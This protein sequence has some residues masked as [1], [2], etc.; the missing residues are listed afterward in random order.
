MYWLE[1]RLLKYEWCEKRDPQHFN[2]YFFKK[3]FFSAP[4]DLK[5]ATRDFQPAIRDKRLLVN[6]PYSNLAV[7]QLHFKMTR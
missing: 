1:G 4:A 7:L 2:Y 5:P 6:N 3:K